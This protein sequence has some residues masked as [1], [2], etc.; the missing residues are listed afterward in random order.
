MKT[1]RSMM[2]IVVAALLLASQASVVVAAPL[3]SSNCVKY[4]QVQPGENLFRIAQKFGTTVT[5]IK[6]LNNLTSDYI[7][8]GQRLRIR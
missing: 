1:R 4:H 3:S 5:E 8:A 6:R 7:Q 2:L